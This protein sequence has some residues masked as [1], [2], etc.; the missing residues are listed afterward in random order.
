MNSIFKKYEWLRLA[1][2]ILLTIIGIIVIVL[3][4]T[5]KNGVTTALNVTLA[6]SLFVLGGVLTLFSIF[7][8]TKSMMSSG[9]IYGA[10]LISLGIAVLVVQDFVSAL[11]VILLAV[12]LITFGAIIIFKGVTLIIYRARWFQYVALFLLGSIGIVFGILAL[13]YRDI[14]FVVTFIVVGVILAA[15]GIA[16]IIIAFIHGKK[17]RDEEKKKISSQ[18]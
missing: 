14:A 16:M 2:G 4:F 9:L 12:F 6:I 10:F 15:T 18:E 1:F 7:S 11:L 17:N 5:N 8:S 3:A 13:N